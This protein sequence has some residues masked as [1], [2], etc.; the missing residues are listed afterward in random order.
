MLYRAGMM[1]LGC[2]VALTVA[3]GCDD[4]KGGAKAG[5]TAKTAAA[6]PT[7]KATAK[8]TA[9]ATTEAKADKVE[10]ALSV[11]ELQDQFKADPKKLLDQKVK[12]QGLYL[13]TNKSKSGG[14][15]TISLS[16]VESKEDTKTNTS[17]AVAEEPK[18]LTQYDAVL[19]EGTV[20]KLFGASLKDCTVK[21]L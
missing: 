16:I 1:V 19:V 2:A 5:A 8:P 20:E 15:E 13:N 10:G 4:S 6:K 21:K 12:V 18:D 11:K 3:G 9:T 14:K 7:A 17:C